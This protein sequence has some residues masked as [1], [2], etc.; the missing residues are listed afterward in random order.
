MRPRGS[1]RESD[2]AAAIGGLWYPN[3]A[4][5]GS[6]P[7]PGCWGGT[8]L[9]RLSE[10]SAFRKE[11]TEVADSLGSTEARKVSEATLNAAKAEIYRGACGCP[12]G[13]GESTIQPVGVFPP[14]AGT[15]A[16]S[17]AA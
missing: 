3:R 6:P 12:T 7:P 11:L 13:S 4:V 17:R 5:V 1:E 10:D 16:A 14:S 9:A 8:M 15:S 2:S